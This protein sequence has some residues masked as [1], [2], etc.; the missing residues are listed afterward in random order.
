MMMIRSLCFFV[1]T[2]VLIGFPC[3][4]FALPPS[5]VQRAADNGREAQ[6]SWF[7]WGRKKAHDAYDSADEAKNKVKN[8]IMGQV[9]R[10]HKRADDT[11][12]QVKHQADKA[13]GAVEEGKEYLHNQAEKARTR[14]AETKDQAKAHAER[15]TGK[16]AVG[17]E[18][19]KYAAKEQADRANQSGN[20]LVRKLRGLFGRQ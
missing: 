9:D 2:F 12:E 1:F 11:K 5:S 17:K 7:R 19:L 6:S 8:K 15:L 14:T 4:A 3:I 16:A 20:W 10:A 18:H 13:R